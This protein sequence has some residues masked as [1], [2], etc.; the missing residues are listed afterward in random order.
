MIP[1]LEAHDPFPPPSAARADG[2]LAASR[3]LTPTRLLDAYRRG[4]FPWFC[5]GDPVLWWT[6]NP[7]TVLFPEEFR[8]SRSLSRTLRRGNFRVR[9]DTAFSQVIDACANTPRPGQDG[10]WITASIRSAYSALHQAG[11]AHSV[12]TWRAD[13][14]GE[15]LIGGLYGV[16]IGGMFYGESMFAHCADASKIAFAHLIRYLRQYEFGLLDCQAP[17][18]HLFS[19]GAREIPRAEF[20]RHLALLTAKPTAPG[21]WPED[22][23]A[24]PWPGGKNR[25]HA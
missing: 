19:L 3:D 16:A 5:A 20:L 18:K 7:R 22:G 9:L 2:L 4:I 11:W 1:W 13:A 10:T 25:F 23:A 15:T 12:E 24:Q 21:L 8:L 6:P 14:D 17:T